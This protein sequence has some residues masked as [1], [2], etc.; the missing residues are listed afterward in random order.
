MRTDK[1]QYLA[2][3][4]VKMKYDMMHVTIQYTLATENRRQRTFVE[5]LRFTKLHATFA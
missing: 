2:L 4:Q 1:P 5:N 3:P